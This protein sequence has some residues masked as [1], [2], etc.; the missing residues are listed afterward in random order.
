MQDLNKSHTDNTDFPYH[1]LFYE[2][3]NNGVHKNVFKKSPTKNFIIENLLAIDA[4]ECNGDCVRL[5]PHLLVGRLDV[6]TKNSKTNNVKDAQKRAFLSPF[7]TPKNIGISLDSKTLQK[8]FVL[9]NFPSNANK[10]DILIAK[11]R[12]LK[13]GKR[14]GV[15]VNKL[16]AEFITTIIPKVPINICVAIE[17]KGSIMGFALRERKLIALKASQK[18]LRA[19]P[20]QAVLSVNI[21]TCEILE[22]LGVFENAMIDKDIVLKEYGIESEFSKECMRYTQSIEKS[23]KKGDKFIIDG[24]LYPHREDYT[25]IPFCVI[26]PKD[27]KD[28]DDAIYYDTKAKKLYVAIADVGEYVAINTPLDNDAKKRCFSVYFPDCVV[29][30]LPFALSSGLCSLQ[31]KEQRLALVWE[32]SIKNGEMLNASLKEGIIKVKESFTYE[33]IAN[34]IESNK[35]KKGLSWLKSYIAQVEKLRNKR[36]KMGYEFESLQA[37]ITLQGNGEVASFAP[38]ATSSAQKQANALSHSIIEESM[39]L[40]NVAS[41]NLLVSIS[42]Q[43]AMYRIH[44]SPKPEKIAELL[45]YLRSFENTF[46]QGKDSKN[47]KKIVKKSSNSLHTEITQIQK[48]AKEFGLQ[49][50]IDWLIIK[51]QSKAV[52]S[53]I[54]DSH[55]GLG[56]A[57]YTHFTSPIRRYS[58]LCVHRIL[59]AFLRGSNEVAYLTKNLEAIA[60]ELNA[61]ERE[62][63]RLYFDFLDLKFARFCAKNTHKITCKSVVIDEGP[64]SICVALDTIPEARITVESS[65]FGKFAILHLR[66]VGA[67][68]ITREIIGEVIACESAGLSKQDKPKQKQAQKRHYKKPTRLNKHTKNKT[69]RGKN[70]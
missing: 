52:Y 6:V 37:H 63:M 19:L 1:L 13:Q 64:P 41:A 51:S 68:I 33:K 43:R 58:D 70:V 49:Q 17:H 46:T 7:Y 28:H 35:F 66:I 48:V 39:L 38:K 67:N 3:Y 59:K 16:V 57:C 22:V 44:Q 32:I 30:M 21:Q 10:G 61:K 27:A 42:P 24:S 26:D 18:S 47:T 9:R 45:A 15:M 55:F 2:L 62:I 4:L 25:H 31:S 12:Y 69:K 29:P 14:A 20:K 36:L 8:D 5:K 65:N 54:A 56:F 34:Y 23:F 50:I 60:R 11:I 53:H 40:A